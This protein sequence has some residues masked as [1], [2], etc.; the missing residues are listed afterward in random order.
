M[1]SKREF[2]LFAVFAVGAVVLSFLSGAV[3]LFCR[4]LCQGY[5]NF[6]GLVAETEL[7]PVNAG[8]GSMLESIWM[9]NAQEL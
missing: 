8:F 7:V 9:D 2:L 6:A 1:G 4:S 5:E 3:M